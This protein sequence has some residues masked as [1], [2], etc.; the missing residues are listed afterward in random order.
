MKLF[1]YLVVCILSICSQA[2]VSL[3]KVQVYSYSPG[4]FGKSNT[5]ICRVSGFH[6]PDI[7]IDLLVDED[8]MTEGKQ[9]DLAFEQGWMFHLMKSAHFIPQMGKKYSCRVKHMQKTQTFVW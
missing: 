8:K 3:P 5:L 4:E 6:P 9:S 2:K 1:L 7:S